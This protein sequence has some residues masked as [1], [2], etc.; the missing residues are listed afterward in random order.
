MFCGFFIC[1]ELDLTEGAT[2]RREWV[3]HPL[4][5]CGVANRWD[6]DISDQPDELGRQRP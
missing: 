4:C 3:A 2:L 6:V 1:S 5:R